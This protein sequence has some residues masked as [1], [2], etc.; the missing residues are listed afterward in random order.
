M[1][2]SSKS[3]KSNCKPRGPSSDSKAKKTKSMD[4]LLGISAM[5]VEPVMRTE[6]EDLREIK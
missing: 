1:A 3:Q 5:E 2:R 6:E 4:E